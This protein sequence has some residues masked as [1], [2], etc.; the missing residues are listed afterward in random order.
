MITATKRLMSQRFR[1]MTQKIEK[2]QEM[3]DSESIVEYIGA[4]N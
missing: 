3:K 2:K 1:T 4:V